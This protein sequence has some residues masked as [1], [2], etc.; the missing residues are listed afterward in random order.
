VR[1]LEQDLKVAGAEVWVYHS[2]VR[3]GESIIHQVNDALTWCDTLLLVW[4]YAASH[5]K[6]V[7]HEWG[8][9]FNAGKK[10]IPCRIDEEPLPILL[11]ITAYVRFQN[12]DQG[13]MDLLEAL[14]LF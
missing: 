13:L 12:Y 2:C 1:R 3:P 11:D 14:G 7:E 5:S 10:L 6:W 4:S 9:V 8:S